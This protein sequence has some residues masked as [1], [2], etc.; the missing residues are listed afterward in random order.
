[1]TIG[2]SHSFS[3]AT[4][5]TLAQPQGQEIYLLIGLCKETV[6]E[7]MRS[8]TMKYAVTYISSGGESGAKVH[9]DIIEITGWRISQVYIGYVKTSTLLGIPIR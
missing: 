3:E 6:K 8:E 4:D 9:C 7:S 2:N 1:M 5:I